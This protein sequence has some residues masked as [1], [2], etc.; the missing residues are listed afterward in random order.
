MIIRIL[1]VND[2]GVLAP[3]LWV[4]VEELA[5]VGEV[6][7]VAPDR[8]QSGVGTGVTLHHPVRASKMVHVPLPVEAYSVQGTPG[9]CVILGLQALAHGPVD[10]V[11]SG[12]NEGANLGSDVLVSGTVGAALQGHFHEVPSIAVSTSAIHEPIFEPAAKLAAALAEELAAGHMPADL[13]LNVNLPN[14]PIDEIKGIAVTRLAHR[15]PTGFLEHQKD[16]RGRAYYWLRYGKP[17]WVVEEGTDLWALRNGIASITPL[18]ADLA[19]RPQVAAIERL[20]PD[21]YRKLAS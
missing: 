17:E 1:V 10:I 16:A 3:G 5:K 8:E 11:V 2:D 13:F 7:V 18:Q 15:R 21:L 12:I 9:D 19:C 14:R 4:L 6:I 20:C